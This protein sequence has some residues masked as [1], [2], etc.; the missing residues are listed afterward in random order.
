M[1]LSQKND[2]V[3]GHDNA[4][5]SVSGEDMLVQRENE[6]VGKHMLNGSE[7]HNSMSSAMDMALSQKNDEVGGHD[8]AS[9]SVSGEDMPVQLKWTAHGVETLQR[10]Q[11]YNDFESPDVGSSLT[12][13]QREMMAMLGDSENEFVGKQMLEGSEQHNSLSSGTDMALSQK[14]DEVGGHDNASSSVTAL[15]LEQ[16]HLNQSADVVLAARVHEKIV[17]QTRISDD[18]VGHNDVDGSASAV[19]DKTSPLHPKW[20]AFGV[21]TL[22]RMQFYADFN[23]PEVGSHAT[24]AQR[25]MMAKL[26][27]SEEEFLTKQLLISADADAP[28]GDESGNHEDDV[29]EG[30]K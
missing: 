10:L 25:K 4:S 19:R 20:T 24:E 3:G 18:D 17:A 11:Y 5:S 7:Q 23:S 29:L 15:M 12:D 1:A 21:D 16:D 13:A 27:D 28:N 6:F 30:E 9:S 14:N 2:E 26:G 8:E 22:R